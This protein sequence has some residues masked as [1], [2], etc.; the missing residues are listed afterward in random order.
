MMQRVLHI[1]SEYEDE[2]GMFDESFTVENM[3]RI[4]NIISI[5]VS[6]DSFYEFNSVIYNFI[7]KTCA[8]KMVFRI[9]KD[10]LNY[11]NIKE[12]NIIFSEIYHDINHEKH[13][14]KISV[15]TASRSIINTDGIFN[16]KLSDLHG[17]LVDLCAEK[18]NDYALRSEY[19]DFIRMLRFFASVNYGSVDLLH[20]VMKSEFTADIL[21]DEFK[22]FNVVNTTSVEIACL[23]EI[24]EYDTL[25]SI[26]VEVSPKEIILHNWKKFSESE[27]PETLINIFDDRV[28]CCDGCLL[29]NE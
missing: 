1:N 21:D 5:I 22:E 7:L 10:D 11:L 14:S 16:F 20:V 18:C 29:C 25:V 6:Y 3:C 13:I 15:L 24:V 23:N 28:K 27:I 19:L 9:L 4:G 17:E 2:L 26:L 12:Q 8:K